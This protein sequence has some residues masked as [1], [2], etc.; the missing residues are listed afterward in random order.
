MLKV[1]NIMGMK[2][3]KTTEKAQDLLSRT[4]ITFLEATGSLDI[5]C[6][7]NICKESTETLF[8]W[9]AHFI[10]LISPLPK[11]RKTVIWRIVIDI[12]TRNSV[13]TKHYTVGGILIHV[14]YHSQLLCMKLTRQP[15][16]KSIKE[17]PIIFVESSSFL[18][19]QN[20]WMLWDGRWWIRILSKN[21][22]IKQFKIRPLM[23]SD[24][25]QL[26]TLIH[27]ADTYYKKKMLYSLKTIKG[28]TK[29]T[30]PLVE[31]EINII[32]LPTL[33]IIFDESV[34]IETKFKVDIST[35]LYNI[36]V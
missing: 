2:R 29:F 23:M 26:Y 24:M 4:H 5:S 27:T 22:I 19:P 33:G 18:N 21:N 12:F 25:K 3:I 36:K 13:K 1:A 10:S 30:V 15:Y 17:F 28:Y 8:K 34:T 14:I 35:Q 20:T 11:Q 32:G 7:T 31:S 16:I 6:N 9:I